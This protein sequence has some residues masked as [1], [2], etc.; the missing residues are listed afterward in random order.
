MWF[1]IQIFRSLSY[2]STALCDHKSI[3]SNPE[4]LIDKVHCFLSHFFPNNHLLS[5]FNSLLALLYVS[6]HN[7][8]RC[9]TCEYLSTV[10][11]SHGKM[12][13]LSSDH[14]LYKPLIIPFCFRQSKSKFCNEGLQVKRTTSQKDD[15][16]LPGS[17]YKGKEVHLVQSK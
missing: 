1:I 15:Q 8:M 12:P 5:F 17:F 16:K 2:L 11:K 9:K 3:D 4:K 6:F 13:L 10:W 7:A 14:M